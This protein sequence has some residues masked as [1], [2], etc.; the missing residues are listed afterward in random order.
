MNAHQPKMKLIS[1]V[2]ACFN[3]EENVE[4]LYER[5][6]AQI[7]K[8]GRYRYEHIFIDNCSTDGTVTILKRI[9]AKDPRVKI[10][11][12]ARN[13]GHIRSP[14]HALMQ[15]TGDAVIGTV[16]DLQDPPELI[17]EIVE[18]WEQGYAMVLCVKRSS[19]ENPMAFWIRKQY[20]RAIEKISETPTFENFTGFGLYDRRVVEAI[21]AI[22]DPYPYFRGMI[23]EVGL[24]SCE[25]PYDQPRRE[26]GT[27]KNNLYTLYDMAMLAITQLSKIPLRFVTFVGFVT[28]LLSVLAGVAYFVYK[29]V[30]WSHFSVGIAPVVIGMF[31]FASVQMLSLGIIGEYVGSI[32]THVRKRPYVIERERVN[33]DRVS[34]EADGKVSAPVPIRRRTTA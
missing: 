7:E 32:Y 28:S 27:T 23:A 20:Y 34:E 30:F 16:A 29:L 33:F 25:I 31:F 11:V 19:Q 24:P 1:V 5:V 2:T 4:T 22:D 10:I 9:A 15:A 14:M 18:R 13:F 3:E 26:R 12:N 8:L 17:P 6:R 21:R